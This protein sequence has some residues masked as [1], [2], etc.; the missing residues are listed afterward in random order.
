MRRVRPAQLFFWLALV[1]AATGVSLFR[2]VSFH[3]A[4]F[5]DE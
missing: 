4:G 3:R 1:L 2:W 5:I